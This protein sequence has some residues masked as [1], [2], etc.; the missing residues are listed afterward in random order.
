MKWK[1]DYVEDRGIVQV[2]TTGKMSWEERRKLTEDALAAGR[3]MNFSAFLV[4]QKETAFGLSAQEINRLPVV[5]RD[6]GF[7]PEDRMAILIN[8]GSINGSSLRFLQ[9]VLCLSLL[10]VQ[11]FTDHKEATAWLKTRTKT[12]KMCV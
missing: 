7:G 5:L 1:I 10:R 11:V 3:K 2:K 12:R 8:P 4:D 9:N 6:I